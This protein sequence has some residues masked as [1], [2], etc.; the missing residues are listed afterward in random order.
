MDALEGTI[1]GLKKLKAKQPAIRKK[2]AT[3]SKCY[4]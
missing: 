1:N 2:K 4:F 3:C